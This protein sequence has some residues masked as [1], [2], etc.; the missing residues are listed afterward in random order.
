MKPASIK[1][2]LILVT[3]LAVPGFLYY[4]LQDKG[5]NRYRPLP[6]FGE[7]T[8]SGTFHT[9]RGQKIPDTTYHTL[10]N[11]E[12]KNQAG[13]PVSLAGKEPKVVVAGLLYSRGGDPVA[14]TAKALEGLNLIYERNPL[15]RFIT[16]S[17]DPADNPE[18]LRTFGKKYKAAAGKW[19][20][21]SGDTAVVY[22]FIR[23]ELLLDIVPKQDGQGFVYSNKLVLIDTQRRIRGFYD[24]A[25][26]EEVAK[27]DDE[28]KVLVAETLRDVRDGR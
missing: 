16:L 11:L 6:I 19:D 18:T 27:L 21:L 9:R 17:V 23:R 3:I 28:I 7:K 14:L 20:L 12:L 22:P 8:L 4:L 13:N 5:K 26:P 10:R 15:I 1:K 2:I 24:A 25:N